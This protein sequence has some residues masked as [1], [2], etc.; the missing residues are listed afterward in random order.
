MKRYFILIITLFVLTVA[1]GQ[2]KEINSFFIDKRK[3]QMFGNKKWKKIAEE[4]KPYITLENNIIKYIKVIE[5]PNKTKEELFE[6]VKNWANYN[7]NTPEFI[8]RSIDNDNYSVTVQGYVNKVAEHSGMLNSY[9]V[10]LKP[11]VTIQVKEGKIRVTFNLPQYNVHKQEYG[12]PFCGDSFL[13]EIWNIGMCYPFIPSMYDGHPAASAKALV[14][15]HVCA[16]MYMEEIEHDLK[17]NQYNS[18]GNNGNNNW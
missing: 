6:K 8:V 11:M 15:T 10:S 1:N 9:E 17:Y 7:F 5:I 13:N 18:S 2:I 16:T 12:G 3:T 4:L 14:M